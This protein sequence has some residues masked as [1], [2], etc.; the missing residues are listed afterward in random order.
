MKMKLVYAAFAFVMNQ[1]QDGIVLIMERKYL[2][3]AEDAK[4]GL[5]KQK[6]KESNQQQFY[7]AIGLTLFNL[8]KSCK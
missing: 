7:I 2:I 5:A 4:T 3:G 8:L 6:K 1:T